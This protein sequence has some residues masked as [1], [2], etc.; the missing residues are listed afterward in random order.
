MARH[1]VLLTHKYVVFA[2]PLHTMAS[3]KNEIYCIIM[4]LCIMVGFRDFCDSEFQVFNLQKLS[5]F[6]AGITKLITF[7]QVFL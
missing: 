4:D 7:T 5:I 6:L 2:Y 3:R 1:L